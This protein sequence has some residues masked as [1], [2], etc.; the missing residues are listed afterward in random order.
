MIN[1]EEK[2]WEKRPCDK[3]HNRPS[4]LK[5]FKPVFTVVWVTTACS[6]IV[7]IA[8]LIPHWLPM[9]CSPAYVTSSVQFCQNSHTFRAPLMIAK[10]IVL[11]STL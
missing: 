10:P 5:T 1:Y 4:G 11:L 2:D 3:Y 8:I 9:L 7:P 6:S